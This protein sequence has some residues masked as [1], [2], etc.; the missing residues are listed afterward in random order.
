MSYE[1]MISEFYL[2]QLISTKHQLFQNIAIY[3]A[4]PIGTKPKH[5]YYTV[6]C[7]DAHKGKQQPS[8][9]WGNELHFLYTITFVISDSNIICTCHSKVGLFFIYYVVQKCNP[10][11]WTVAYNSW[12]WVTNTLLLS[13][14]QQTK[15]V[16][17]Q[18][19]SCHGPHTESA[20]HNKYQ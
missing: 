14:R 16:L 11:R 15:R 3:W 7:F 18:R 20:P 2:L 12:Q 5:D 10:K 17:L 19:E 13:V 4:A 6:L 8:S 9:F 1:S